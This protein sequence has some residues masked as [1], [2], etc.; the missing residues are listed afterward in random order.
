MAA[1]QSPGGAWKAQDGQCVCKRDGRV[2]HV[3]WQFDTR[4]PSGWCGY[5]VRAAW[6]EGE[7][8]DWPGR[9]SIARLH[10][11]SGMLIISEFGFLQTAVPYEYRDVEIPDDD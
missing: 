4:A 5:S 1:R 8:I 3:Q 11:P 6:R 9:G 2:S 7:R 10:H